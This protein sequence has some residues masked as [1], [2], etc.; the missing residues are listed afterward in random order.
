[1]DASLVQSWSGNNGQAGGFSLTVT[2]SGATAGNRLVAIASVRHASSATIVPEADY[3]EVYYDYDTAQGGILLAERIATGDASDNYNITIT[4]AFERPIAIIVQEWSGLPSS[5]TYDAVN[6]NSSDAADVQSITTGSVTPSGQPG[7]AITALAV[8]DQNDWAPTVAVD[9][10]FGNMEEE[11]ASVSNAAYAAVAYKT[12]T[13]TASINPTWDTQDVNSTPV[14]AAVVVYLEDTGTSVDVTP[15]TG[16]AEVTGYAPTININAP[17]GPMDVANQWLAGNGNN[18]AADI[19]VTVSGATAGSKLVAFLMCRF[20]AQRPFTPPT[21]W[22]QTAKFVCNIDSPNLNHEAYIFERIATGDSN[23]NFYATYDFARNMA[24]VISEL[25]NPYAVLGNVGFGTDPANSGWVVASSVTT[26][27]VTPTRAAGIAFAVMG[28]KDRQDHLSSGIPNSTTALSIGG[29]YGDLVVA[30]TGENNAAAAAVAYKNY[31]DLSEITSATWASTVGNAEYCFGAVVCY[32]DSGETVDVDITVPTGGV[33]ATG[34]VP[35]SGTAPT[36]EAGGPY[37]GE[38]DTAIALSSTVTP[39]SDSNPTLLWEIV[40][41]GTGTFSSTSVA[42][43]TFTPDVAGLYIL[44]LTATPNDAEAVSDNASLTSLA[45][46]GVWTATNMTTALDAEGLDGTPNTATTLTATAANATIMADAITLPSGNH[47]TRWFVKRKTGTGPV[48]ITID[49]GSTWVEIQVTATTVFRQRLLEDTLANP[50]IG[51]K[52]V[53]SGDEVIVGNTELN[54]F[55]TIADITGAQHIYAFNYPVTMLVDAAQEQTG[56]WSGENWVAFPINSRFYPI[57]EGTGSSVKDT[58]GGNTGTIQNFDEAAWG[59]APDPGTY[60]FFVD[61]V[62]V[63]SDKS[64]KVISDTRNNLLALVHV[65]T[66]GSIQGWEYS[67]DDGTG[68]ADEPQY[69]YYKKSARWIQGEMTW[70]NGT[71]TQIVWR[72]S[73][74]SGGAYDTIGTESVTYD[75]DGNVETVTWA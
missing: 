35:V 52:I 23:D 37:S 22:T 20:G 51:A 19:S 7:V 31:S 32:A 17:A 12:F 15:P 50:Q 48:Q 11:Y 74:N 63:T 39:G 10:G 55:T 66:M 27:T 34:Y 5:G 9:S 21:G 25:T 42:D 54:P 1:M 18:V 64:L 72:Y 41:G 29:S 30:H 36:V 3:D 56:L 59:S 67:K 60:K 47:V 43:P 70:A 46:D 69:L 65:A 58:L 73:V 8:R 40:S 2:V 14:S 28:I 71:I 68:T 6:G 62:P 4:S 57:D 38:I 26:G 45:A 49:G 53:T 33:A 13:S 61:G 75:T 24:C 44:R 16:S